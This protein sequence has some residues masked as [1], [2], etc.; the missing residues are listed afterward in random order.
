MN[1]VKAILIEDIYPEWNLIKGSLVLARSSGVYASHPLKGY[2]EE[3]VAIKPIDPA[4]H[5]PLTEKWYKHVF[6]SSLEYVKETIL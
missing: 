1:I 5:L 6:D 3:L 4:T 2:D